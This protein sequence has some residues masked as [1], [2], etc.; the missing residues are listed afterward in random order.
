[1]VGG[2][3][4]VGDG[5]AIDGTVQHLDEAPHWQDSEGETL[6]VVDGEDAGEISVE[7][8]LVP[9]GGDRRDEL[10][11]QTTLADWEGSP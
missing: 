11:G 1:M 9:N 4:E 8:V 5:V 7:N 3:R 10:Q 2:T 6:D